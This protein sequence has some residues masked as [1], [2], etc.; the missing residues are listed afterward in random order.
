[1]IKIPKAFEIKVSK[2]L[3]IF[4]VLTHI[5]YFVIIKSNKQKFEVK[6]MINI[7]Q[8]RQDDISRLAEIEIFN[9]RLNFN[10]SF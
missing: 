4:I 5:V 3:S 1:M 9:Y 8:A 2:A 10:Y 7:R 6:K